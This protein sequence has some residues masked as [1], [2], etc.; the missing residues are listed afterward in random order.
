LPIFKI[1]AEPE[2]VVE[3]GLLQGWV[4]DADFTFCFDEPKE[5]IR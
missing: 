2:G 4:G 1:V 3:V 5:A